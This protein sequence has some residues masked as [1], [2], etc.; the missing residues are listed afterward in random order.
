MLSKAIKDVTEA[1]KLY[2]V[3]TY[4][5]Y[6]EISSKYKR[7]FLGSLW[8]SG[9]LVAT[10]IALSLVFGGIFGTTLKETLP[11]MMCGIMCFGLVGFVMTE[12]VEIFMGAGNMIKNHANPFSYYVLEAGAKTFFLFLHNVV[13]FY[14]MLLLIGA[15]QFPHPSLLL[16]IVVVLVTMFSW[17]TV[18]GMLAARFRDM[19]YLLPY[20][21]HIMYFMTPI[22]WRMDQLHSARAKYAQMNPFYGLVEILRAPLLGQEAPVH[23]WTLALVS[24]I[25]GLVVWILVFGAWRRRIPFWL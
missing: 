19:R 2:H 9:Q 17:G 5:A 14:I 24:M 20:L 4:Q 13:V 3:W 8:I 11:Y 1:F 25:S 18:T 12:S 21:A 6:H 7:T 16:G 23:C 15:I 22:F 10:S